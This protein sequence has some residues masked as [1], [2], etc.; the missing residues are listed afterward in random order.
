MGMHRDIPLDIAFSEGKLRVTSY[1]DEREAGEIEQKT[2]SQYRPNSFKLFIFKVSYNVNLLCLISSLKCILFILS[3]YK[4]VGI[5]GAELL[6]PF[7]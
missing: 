3:I 7:T 1:L 5:P 2:R 6:G 4:Q